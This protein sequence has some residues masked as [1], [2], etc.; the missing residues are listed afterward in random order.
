MTI[1]DDL[2]L[3]L[4]DLA[5]DAGPVHGEVTAQ[6]AV[7]RAQTQRRTRLAVLGAATAT[8]LIA[9]GVPIAIGA[10]TGS[11]APRVAAPAS[12]SA[13]PAA[14]PTGAGRT[15]QLGPGL[16][17]QIGPSH[18]AVGTA[19][20][21]DVYSHCG[22]RSI[23]FGGRRWQASPPAPEPELR[24]P[25]GADTVTYNGYTSGVMILVRPDLLR[26]TVTDPDVLRPTGPIDFVPLKAGQHPG[27]CD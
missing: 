1:P 14:T 10:G 13:S 27:L 19:Y 22:F 15:Q 9:V 4:H 2:R 7:A 11:P 6:L 3:R 21:F 5:D 12:T 18:A 25:K 16:T 20:P 26:F 17:V 8:V 23:T 24:T